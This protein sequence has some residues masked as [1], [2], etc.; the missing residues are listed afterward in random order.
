MYIHNATLYNTFSLTVF[1]LEW[2]SAIKDTIGDLHFVLYRVVSLTEGLCVFRFI[3]HQYYLCMY[4]HD[5]MA[6]EKL[7]MCSY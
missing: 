2:N 4:A 3:D 6:Q 5:G 7:L 1:E